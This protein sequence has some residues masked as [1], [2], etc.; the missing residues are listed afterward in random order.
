MANTCNNYL[1]VSASSENSKKQLKQFM[2][3]NISPD[4]NFSYGSLLPVPEDLK[5]TEESATDNGLA[6]IQARNGDPTTLTELLKSPFYVKMNFKTI[7]ELEN[8]LLANNQANLIEGQQ[9]YL[10]IIKYG[11]KSWYDWCLKNWG[12]KWDAS[13]VKILLKNDEECKI[14]FYSP[15]N[16]PDE[17]LVFA[18]KA[19]P[20]LVFS[21]DYEIVWSNV[22]TEGIFEVQNGSVLFEE[23]DQAPFSDEIKSD[24]VKDYGDGFILRPKDSN[25]EFLQFTLFVKNSE[26][27]IALCN[28][29]YELKKEQVQ[30]AILEDIFKSIKKDNKDLLKYSVWTNENNMHVNF[31]FRI[32]KETISETINECTQILEYIRKE[33]NHRFNQNDQ[34]I[35]L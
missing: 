9:A 4:S 11:C 16:P 7:E 32:E 28:D 34:I 24:I 20:D 30:T 25:D 3:D 19:Y 17:W 1:T 22:I 26:Y 2:E 6:I 18:S 33:H 21:D 5:I 23:I 13:E 8:Y 27:I 10:N 35:G 14:Y 29:T 12:V 15:Y 31:F